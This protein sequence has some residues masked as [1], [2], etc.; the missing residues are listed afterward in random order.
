[1]GTSPTASLNFGR[2]R[3][4]KQTLPKQ[5]IALLPSKVP[6]LNAW[7]LRDTACRWYLHGNQGNITSLL[8]TFPR[9]VASDTPRALMA[10]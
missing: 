8:P 1:M 6:L 7:L 3:G 5:S 9:A 2:G 10:V 4:S